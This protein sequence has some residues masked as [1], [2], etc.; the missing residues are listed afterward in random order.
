MS[1]KQIIV[2]D[3]HGKVRIEICLVLAGGYGDERLRRNSICVIMK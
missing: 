1:G 2:H 3:I